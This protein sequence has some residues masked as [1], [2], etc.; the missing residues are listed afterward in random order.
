MTHVYP[1]LVTF[2]QLNSTF[3]TSSKWRVWFIFSSLL[4]VLKFG[5]SLTP[6]VH[7]SVFG[8]DL[9]AVP[10]DVRL[11]GCSVVQT[12][13]SEVWCVTALSV[14][15]I[16]SVGCRWREHRWHDTDSERRSAAGKTGL[17]ATSCSTDPTHIGLAS[18][19]VSAA[20]NRAVWQKC[21]DVSWKRTAPWKYATVLVPRRWKLLF[22]ETSVKVC[23]DARRHPV[24]C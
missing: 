22:S 23:G 7:V 5:R 15:K 19:R 6:N 3:V 16:H 10:A 2:Q 20:T 13:K 14:A 9:T 1:L 11:V 18:D 21:T 8:C 12:G 4:T 24:R 17:S